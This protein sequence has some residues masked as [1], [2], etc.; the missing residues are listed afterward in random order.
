MFGSESKS[1]VP[2]LGSSVAQ[3]QDAS[4]DEVPE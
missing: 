4:G 2:P 1:Y 3:V